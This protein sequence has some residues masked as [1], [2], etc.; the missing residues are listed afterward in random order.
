MDNFSI[1]VVAPS[2]VLMRVLQHELQL[3]DAKTVL[4]CCDM[5]SAWQLLQ[6]NPIDLVISSM[7]FEDGDSLAL[8]QRIKNDQAFSNT[9]FMLI[10]SEQRSECLEPIRHSGVLAILPRPFSR[11]QLE[12]ALETCLSMKNFDAAADTESAVRQKRV[13]MV[14]DSKLA[15]H[16]MKKVLVQS[17]VPEHLIVLA[18][19]GQEAIEIIEKG[20]DFDLV[21]TDYHMPNVDGEGLLNYIRQHEMLCNLPVIMV[22]S[23][24]NETRLGSIRSHGVT[25]LM[26]KP[27]DVIHLK[28]LLER[29]LV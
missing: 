22:T 20:A 14:D 15:R 28:T 11:D 6:E 16:H 1:L 5:V 3:L 19:D 7:Y 26:D 2:R 21:V 27:F 9:L 8:L 23:E 17:G 25:A 24:N 13:L 29:H 12:R 18:E 4:A 10:S